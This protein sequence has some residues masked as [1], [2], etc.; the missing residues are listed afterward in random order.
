LTVPPLRARGD[1]VVVLAEHFRHLF[2]HESSQPIA[3]FSDAALR[4]IASY[5]WPGNVRELINRVRR[6]LVIAE[7]Y[8]ISP[9]D[10]GF[11][12]R[13]CLSNFC[14]KN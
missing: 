10:L 4:T 12:H 9:L 6:A 13:R 7:G 8:R 5:H 3:G 11:E 2:A 1:D 14:V